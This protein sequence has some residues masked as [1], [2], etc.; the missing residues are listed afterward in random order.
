M[1]GA[2]SMQVRWTVAAVAAAVLALPRLLAAQGPAQGI[3]VQGHWVIEVRDADGTLRV[4]REFEN[5]LTGQGRQT[6][7]EVLGG[8]SP[9]GGWIVFAQGVTGT[10]LCTNPQ[11]SSI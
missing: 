4:R 3:K 11:N 8:T 10:A 6:L 7:A 1:R 9:M 2:G 5:A